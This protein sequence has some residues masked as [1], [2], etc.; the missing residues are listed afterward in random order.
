MS[1]VSKWVTSIF[2]AHVR[3]NFFSGVRAKNR[4]LDFQSSLLTLGRAQVNLV[5]L[6]LN[7]SLDFQSSLLTLGRAQVNLVLL[8]LNR[9][10]DTCLATSRWRLSSMTCSWNARPMRS[11]K[12]SACHSQTRHRSENC[13]IRHIPMMSKSNRAPLFRGCLINI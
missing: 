8:S 12:S 6:S 3:E 9:S 4:S 13:S 11:Y 2:S 7:R 5:L 10:L 1:E